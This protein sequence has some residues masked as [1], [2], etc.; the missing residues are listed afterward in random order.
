LSEKEIIQGCQKG[1]EACQKALVEQY[2]PLLLTVCRGFFRDEAQ[3]KDILQEALI[4]ILLNIKKYKDTGS[5]V[6]WMRRITVN[7]AL[8]AIRKKDIIREAVELEEV[9]GPARTPD[10]LS[11]LGEEEIL[12]LIAQLPQDQQIVFT[13][14]V[15]EGYSHKEIGEHLGI[16]ASTSRSYLTR[17]RQ[18]LQQFFLKN[19]DVEKGRS[20]QAVRG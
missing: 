14:Y 4:K 12:R 18:K 19:N 13:L 8:K 3:A 11:K 15:V 9:N 10:A 6:G 16:T 1:K 5:F 7:T 2:S 20:Y 17:A